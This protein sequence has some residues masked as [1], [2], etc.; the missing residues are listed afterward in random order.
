MLQDELTI[1]L[2][3][4]LNAR[5]QRAH[6]QRT[7][8]AQYGVPLAVLTMNIAGPV[9]RGE[10]ID[11]GFALGYTLIRRQ[12]RAARMRCLHTDIHILRTGNEAFMAVDADARAL[13]RALLDIEEATPAG[14]LFDIDVLDCDGSQISRAQ[15]GHAQ[16]TCLLCDQ[17]AHACA[18]SRQH[19]LP[20]I[21][22]RT[23]QLLRDALTQWD[24][25][26]IAQQA[27]RALLYEAS[28]TPKPGLVDRAGSG[29]HRD[30]DFF[31]F[32]DSSVSLSEYFE[33]C[34]HIGLQQLQSAAATMAALR[35]LGRLAEGA[36]LAATDGVNTH[37]GAVFTLGVVCAALGRLRPEQRAQPARVLDECAAIAQGITAQ[38][39]AGI[40]TENARTAGEKLYARHGITGARGQLE[41]GLP[42]VRDHG[43][44]A[45]E[46]ALQDGLSLNDA[47][48][49]ALLHLMLHTEDT[50]LMARGG[51]EAGQQVQQEVAA[52]LKRTPHPDHAAL[53]DLDAAFVARNLSPGGSADLLSV[54][55]LLHFMKDDPL[56]MPGQKDQE[57]TEDRDSFGSSALYPHLRTR[58][59]P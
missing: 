41:Q 24:A 48:C 9:K 28:V 10:W 44:P 27:C 20:E 55:F 57:R 58:I 56:Q 14:R 2:E 25:W 54:C 38:D 37:K 15:V 36:M 40:T 39:F 31:T 50:N 7:L 19:G 5:E 53:R 49:L 16:R 32:V 52:L 43:L 13:K 8:L 30:M 4:M 18:R 47:G 11:R 34:A 1:T 6:R 23:Q 26:H 12:L 46:R 22:A 21:T 35:P 33:Q 17:P 29:S 45:L 42:S 3:D 59:A 51:V